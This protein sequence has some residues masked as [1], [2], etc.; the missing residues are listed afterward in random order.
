MG[1][2]VHWRQRRS[3]IRVAPLACAWDKGAFVEC[4][5]QW[6]EAKDLWEP[7]FLVLDFPF[8]HPCPD[9]LLS[10]RDALPGQNI[11]HL[12]QGH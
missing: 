12:F 8:Q 9:L 10:I 7:L 1:A 2:M 11:R 5:P 6:P 4:P 3:G